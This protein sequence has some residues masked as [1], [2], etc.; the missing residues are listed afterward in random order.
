MKFLKLFIDINENTKNF[1]EGTL[2]ANDNSEKKIYFI[3]YYNIN[4]NL[5]C[6]NLNYDDIF[7]LNYPIKIRNN[8][9][10][11]FVSIWNGYCCRL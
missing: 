8:L 5:V 9:N 2:M 1:V 11:S 10:I 3:K 6:K 7:S 4:I